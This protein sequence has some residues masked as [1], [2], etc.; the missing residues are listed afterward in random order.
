MRLVTLFTAAVVAAANVVA[1][2]T[3][4]NITHEPGSLLEGGATECFLHL[5]WGQ[6]CSVHNPFWYAKILELYD[7]NHQA[8]TGT[9]VG[10]NYERLSV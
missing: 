2:P 4:Q 5:V 1:F 9:Y 7:E 10:D 6:A 3:T 8:M